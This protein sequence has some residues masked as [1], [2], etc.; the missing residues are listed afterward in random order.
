VPLRRRGGDA[1]ELGE[2]RGH[3]PDVAEAAALAGGDLVE[4]RVGLGIRPV[5]G[6]ADRLHA[7]GDH[8]PEL[9]VDVGGGVQHRAVHHDAEPSLGD[10]AGGG[11]GR[12]RDDERRGDEEN[13]RE[14]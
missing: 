1:V 11:G 2:V 8:V 9:R 14:L 4:A 6:G 12:G 10:V 7:V 5:E 3:A 13:G